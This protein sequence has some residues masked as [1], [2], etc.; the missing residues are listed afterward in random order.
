MKRETTPWLPEFG[1]GEI[2]RAATILSSLLRGALDSGRMVSLGLSGGMDSRLLLAMLMGIENRGFTVHTFGDALDPD[3][4]TSSVIANT[5][6]LEWKHFDEPLP[7]V[8]SMM[9]MARQFA[10]QLCLVEPVSSFLKLRYYPALH[11]QGR[12]MIDGGFGEI[13]R[14][15]YLNR[16]AR[17]GRSALRLRDTKRLFS[18][19]RVDRGDIF[20]P[21]VKEVM[22]RGAHESLE[23]VL[24]SLPPV[25][26]IGVENSVDLLAIRTRVPNYGAPEQARLDADVINFMPLIQPSFLRPAFSARTTLRSSGWFYRNLIRAHCAPLAGFPLVKSG[27]TYGFGLSTSAAWLLTKVKSKLG[28]SFVDPTPGRF[29]MQGREYILDLAHSSDV[30]E[31]PPYDSRKIRSAVDAY[32]RKRNA[33]LRSTVDWWITFELWRRSLSG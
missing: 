31:W 6:G 10:A 18:L 20:N 13:A 26:E 9:S 7:D 29:L 4:R 21:D 30:A 27:I 33:K 14:R 5:L 25:S 3:V 22:K 12:L 23:R 11:R 24:S 19:M 1:E 17:L 15:Q 32:F 16:V 28:Q 2:T 8:D